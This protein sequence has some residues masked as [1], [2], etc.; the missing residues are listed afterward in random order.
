MSK[1]E[2]VLTPKLRPYKSQN[3]ATLS[4]YVDITLD[5]QTQ[6]IEIKSISGGIYLVWGTGTIANED[7]EFIGD[8]EVRH[9]PR[10]IN[11]TQIRLLEKDTGAEAIIIQK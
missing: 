9:Y 7:Y 3:E 8:G 2:D 11:E 4:S 1:Q 5:D 6:I 10:L